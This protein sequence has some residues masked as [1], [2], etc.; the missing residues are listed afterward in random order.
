MD[1]GP[2]RRMERAPRSCTTATAW[3]LLAILCTPAAAQQSLAAARFIPLWVPQAQFAGY[4]VAFERGLYRT[5]G[6]DLTILPGGPDRPASKALE[7]G[8]AEFAT[9]WLSTA[10]RMRAEGAPIVNVAQ[11]VQ[12]SSVMLIAKASTGITHPGDL[13]GKKI[14]VW[15]GDFLLQP[16]A[17]FKQYHLDVRTVPQ[18]STINLF[19][20]DGVDAA[21]AMWYNEY[22]TILNAGLNPDEL[23]TFFFS[24]HGLNFPEDGLY[25]RADVDRGLCRAFADASLE[26]WQYAFDHADDALDIVMA[27]MARAHLPASRVHQRWMLARMQDVTAP[28]GRTAPLGMLRPESYRQVAAALKDNGWIE[29]IPELTDFSIGRSLP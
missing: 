23:T 1:L 26:G 7:E 22:H 10:I 8:Q 25:C 27:Y 20:R 11:V 19:L 5:H 2:G 24:E 21:V 16:Q 18:A 29:R 3:L 12:R 14:G 28:G 9:L 4:Y 13:N 17:F 6:I 15:E